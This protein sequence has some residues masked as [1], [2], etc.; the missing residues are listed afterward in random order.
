MIHVITRR[1]LWLIQHSRKVGWLSH[2]A[3]TKLPPFEE[4]SPF[5]LFHHQS[6]SVSILNTTVT[7]F[8]GR[9]KTWQSTVMTKL[10][11]KLL[12]IETMFFLF[13]FLQDIQN[14]TAFDFNYHRFKYYVNR[15]ISNTGRFSLLERNSFR[16]R[17]KSWLFN[18]QISL[19]IFH[20]VL[21]KSN[22]INTQSPFNI[23]LPST[24]T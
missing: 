7:P 13:I 15:T 23:L 22:P 11:N 10:L 8:H 16:T 2:W 17:G 20:P 1:R 12:K 21:N 4:N 18:N 5:K 14:L 3:P 19:G 9:E 6:I 24:L